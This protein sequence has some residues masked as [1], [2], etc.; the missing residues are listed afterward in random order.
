LSC[1]NV[2]ATTSFDTHSECY[3]V[4]STLKCTVRA[5]NGAAVAGCMARGTCGSYTI[6][7]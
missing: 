7:E 6:E 3:G 4:D 2:E 1:G 5:T